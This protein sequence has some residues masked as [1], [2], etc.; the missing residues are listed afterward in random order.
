M[1]FVHPDKDMF[2]QLFTS[3]IRPHLEY[4]GPIWNPRA[5]EFIVIMENVQRRAS[6][7]IPVCLI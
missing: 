6:R 5:K 1:S 4:G 2:K 7:Q 3:I